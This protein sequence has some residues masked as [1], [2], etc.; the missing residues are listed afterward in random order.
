MTKKRGKGMENPR[1]GFSIRH[2]P[3]VILVNVKLQDHP[4]NGP[5]A[6]F[7]GVILSGNPL[8]GSPTAKQFTGLFGLPS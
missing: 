3:F 1:L 7:V 4:V 5:A 2:K 8:I 6:V